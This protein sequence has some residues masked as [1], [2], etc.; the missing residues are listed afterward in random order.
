MKQTKKQLT[1][2][3]VPFTGEFYPVPD[4]EPTPV[5]NNLAGYLVIIA[6]ALVAGLSM[7]AMSTYQSASQVQLREM[8]AQSQ[9]LEKV[10]SQVCNRN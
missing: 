6:A 8:K 9:Q 5:G 7:G 3:V 4:P 2:K 10:K 1:S